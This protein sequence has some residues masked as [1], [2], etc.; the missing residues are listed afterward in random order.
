MFHRVLFAVAALI[1]VL[2]VLQYRWIS[3]L[4]ETELVRQRDNVQVGALRFSQEFNGELMRA[5]V[6]VQAGRPEGGRDADESAGRIAGWMASTPYRRMV[7]AFYRTRG[8]GNGLAELLRYNPSAERFDPSPWP[9][10][11]AWPRLAPA[12]RHAPSAS[13]C[14]RS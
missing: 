2:A 13:G 5:F 8:G 4:S 9:A 6:S 11:L 3:Q 12:G 14:R 7:R 1:A 10:Q